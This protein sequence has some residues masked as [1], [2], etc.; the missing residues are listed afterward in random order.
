MSEPRPAQSLLGARMSMFPKLMVAKPTAVLT[1]TDFL[2]DVRT[3]RWRTEVEAIRMANETRGKEA[4]NV[5]KVMLPVV[6]PSGEFNG[7][8]APSLTRHSGLLCLDF[9]EVI[10]PDE[11]ARLVSRDPHVFAC[12][13]SPRGNGLKVFVPVAATNA[14]DHSRCWTAA[15]QHFEPMTRG[16]A[17]LDHATKN[18]ASNCFV[19]YDPDLYVADGAVA[20]FG[21][22]EAG[23]GFLAPAQEGEKKG[24]MSE[25]SEGSEGSV[26][27]MG[28]VGSISH[29]PDTR[30]R[31]ADAERKIEKLED[32][33]KE[34][35][36]VYKAYLANRRVV[37]GGRH[38]LLLK[39]IPALYSVVSEPILIQLLMLHYEAQEGTWRTSADDHLAEISKMISIYGSEYAANL[40]AT[41]REYYEGLDT[42]RA[43]AAFRICR[44]L[45]HLT[46]EKRF[47]L[48]CGELG[49]RVGVRHEQAHRLLK[50]FY[51]DGVICQIA[52][53]KIWSAGVRPTAAS[54][55]W[56]CSW[57]ATATVPSPA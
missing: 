51:A 35:H 39:V 31:R 57:D 37:R 44:D 47:F 50:G 30:R 22:A 21:P 55:A 4:A 56:D 14:T 1:A 24:A 3:G 9:D 10:A 43:K 53:G 20:A 52:P 41:E 42:S 33:N 36:R 16:M 38:E 5:L 18:V 15:H 25:G 45:A 8:A 46:P 29:I 11:L 12:F 19:S 13:K 17:K 7:L 2:G 40:P 23:P 32:Q 48:S 54:W 27:S 6:K 34:L 26:G 49:A 28:S